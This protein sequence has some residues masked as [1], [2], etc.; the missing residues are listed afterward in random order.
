MN[1]SR[2]LLWF[3]TVALGGGG[4]A[5]YL[6][7]AVRDVPAGSRTPAYWF[8][9]LVAL[10]LLVVGVRTSRAP[11]VWTRW[12]FAGTIALALVIT[13]MAGGG[14][15][16]SLAYIAIGVDAAR[17]PARSPARSRAGWGV[18]LAVFG[19]AGLA[20]VEYTNHGHIDVW[21]IAGIGGV[22][23]A[24]LAARERTEL[25]AAEA[26][27]AVLAD[28]AHLAR[29]IHDILAHSLSAQV[30]HLEAA[31]LMLK[32]NGS[33][34]QVLERV[35]QAQRMARNGLAETRRA[36]A[37]LRG[38]AKPVEEALA[39][40][41]EEVSGG[42]LDVRGTPRELSAEAGLAVVRTAQEALTNIRKHAPG[43]RVQVL[44]EYEP[45]A[46]TLEVTDTGAVG[47]PLG[48]GG[49]GYGLVGMR[50]RAELIG[51]ILEAGPCE[52]GFR[53]LLRV[54]A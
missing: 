47:E 9:N 3:R 37:A 46:V 39:E 19:M 6:L 24:G 7:S 42:M 18:G 13:T 53:V 49:S 27:N 4:L 35:E 54:P 16:I 51:G 43:A 21:S 10:A 28:R 17:S 8:L 34:D 52:G 32:Q 44:F 45:S 29:E 20:G 26:R 2:P 5:A 11:R 25:G 14:P 36:L 1:S 50:E 31:R 30:V 33:T 41:V 38:D 23:L 48:L 40:L 22:F 15:A 12:C